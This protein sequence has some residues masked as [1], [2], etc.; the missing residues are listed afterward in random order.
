[1]KLRELRRALDKDAVKRARKPK[2]T[3]KDKRLREARERVTRKG[4]HLQIPGSRTDRRRWDLIGL[5][6]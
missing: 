6:R 3:F 4:V 5:K 2:A 1:M